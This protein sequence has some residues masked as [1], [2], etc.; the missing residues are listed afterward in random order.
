MVGLLTPRTHREW[1]GQEGHP[2]R[3]GRLSPCVSALI[4]RSNIEIQPAGILGPP[5]FL[6]QP[7]G[8]GGFIED[9]RRRIADRLPDRPN[10]AGLFVEIFIP[11]R[12]CH[13]T[14]AGEI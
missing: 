6:V 7:V 1:R 11:L 9:L 12:S 8:K 2:S 4:L 13:E 14:D 10:G 3:T 5:V